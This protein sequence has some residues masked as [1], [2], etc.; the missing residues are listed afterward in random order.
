[1][2]HGLQVI[3]TFE[4]TGSV[5]DREF[6]YTG[7]APQSAVVESIQAKPEIQEKVKRELVQDVQEEELTT[8]EEAPEEGTEDEG[9]ANEV[10][11]NEVVDL[12]EITDDDTTMT[13]TGESQLY[14][15]EVESPQMEQPSECSIEVIDMVDD[16][17]EEPPAKHVIITN[18][19][20]PAKRKLTVKANTVDIPTKVSNK[21]HLPT[22]WICN[23]CG[24]VS[25][26]KRIH[27]THMLVHSDERPHQC[28]E[29][30]MAF[31]RLQGLKRHLLTHTGEKPYVCEVCGLSFAA[32][33]SHQM[34]VRLHTGERPYE[35]RHCGDKFIGL[36]AL[37]VS[38]Y[39]D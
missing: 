24:K 34:H 8:I 13:A 39:I 6:Y 19:R 23:I 21:E 31:V 10:V 5:A 28:T 15:E 33:M 25:K 22:V 12:E 18:Y 32:Y 20:R 4:A 27:K 38:I 29:C 1:M 7:K 9:V 2:S 35:C 37:N 36:P 26:Q 16:D 14:C 11:V 17:E 3:A 30:P